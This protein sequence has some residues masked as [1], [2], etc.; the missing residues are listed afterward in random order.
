MDDG[1]KETATY[2]PEVMP[3]QGWNK[4]QTID[5]LL[6]KGG[7]KGK[8]TEEFRRTI[9][10]TRYQSHKS[11]ASYAEYVAWKQTRG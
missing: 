5:S 1:R 3:E 11:H 8:V 4:I 6:R 7:Y 9:I 2:L 10:L